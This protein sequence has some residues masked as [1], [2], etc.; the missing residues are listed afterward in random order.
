[1]G[2]L[3]VYELYKL[4][5]QRIVILVCMCAIIANAFTFCVVEHNY[6]RY[7]YR[8]EY[9]EKFK[10]VYDK[11]ESAEERI[12]SMQ[13]AGSLSNQYENYFLLSR[14]NMTAA[15]YEKTE[16][17]LVSKYGE[18]ILTDLEDMKKNMDLNTC[19]AFSYFSLEWKKQAEYVKEYN[20]FRNEME[21]RQNQLKFFSVF[22]KEE[23]YSYDN[24]LKTVKDFREL[25]QVDIDIGNHYG[26]QSF[27]D[28]HYS[29]VFIVCIASVLAAGLWQREKGML[30]LLKSKR[31]GKGSLFFAKIAV[32]VAG[33]F[34]M[35]L[36]CRGIEVC[37]SN[38]FYGMGN[39][40][41]SIQSISTYRN[42][43]L[44][45]TA[46][47]FMILCSLTQAVV[48]SAIGILLF[49]LFVVCR[50]NGY[51]YIIGG[52]G[53]VVSSMCYFFIL[54]TG[55]LSFFKYINLV[56]GMQATKLFGTYRNIDL[57]G[58]AVSVILLFAIFL[59]ILIMIG[60]I[61]GLIFWCTGKNIGRNG[62]F[63]IQ[64]SK[65]FRSG[66]SILQVQ[67]NEYFIREK[68]M[69]FCL[70]LLIYGIYTAFYSPLYHYTGTSPDEYFAETYYKD[71]IKDMEGML[72]E[73]TKQKISEREKYFDDVWEQIEIIS[74][75][76]EQD[77]EDYAKLTALNSQTGYPLQAFQELK[78]QYDMVKIR[79]KEGK[80]AVILDKYSWN[81]LFQ[82]AETE[83]KNLMLA[84]IVSIL[85]CG[86]VF[87]DRKKMKSLVASTKKGRRNL[88][89]KKYLIG[90]G[91]GVFAWLCL[92]LPEL[93][94]F[95][96]EK[97]VYLMSAAL[98]NLPLLQQVE[99][100]H[101]IGF[102]V[103]L[104][105]VSS[106]L[107]CVALSCLTMIL[108]D[109]TSDSFIITVSMIAGVSLVG[110]ILIGKKQGVFGAIVLYSTCPVRDL[111]LVSVLLLL[112]I[113]VSITL[114]ECELL[115]PKRKVVFKHGRK[116]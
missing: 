89:R 102:T 14:K 84:G 66:I 47:Q 113:L 23:S 7:I 103:M 90:I 9:Y 61:S 52:T 50:N 60:V 38:Y 77:T 19:R 51:I 25:G 43:C 109:L 45:L 65:K 94:L 76:D 72:T 85:L 17:K 2:K 59:V 108:V 96:R 37:I 104:I 16:K 1:M 79:Q 10:Q 28:Y 8:G 11:P 15:E 54:P 75:K 46:G 98:G 27:L 67:L 83:V 114:W 57:F 116:K 70:L 21:N 29:G 81:R 5:H 3:F 71:E 20:T 73:N 112:P 41:M 56:F 105:Y 111:F 87:S 93:V 95:L 100:E 48:A 110:A 53:L 92:V 115:Y 32:L 63:Q 62:S 18:E 106:L 42:C 107:F 35:T 12:K 82:N 30:T 33:I 68:K 101:S 69:I 34:L 4:F 6:G 24:L 49:L 40:S 78:E 39:L 97:S 36:L 86:T 31:K 58:K 26:I 88:W 80:N 74:K 13:R 91:G 44:K 99:E 64:F 55:S 22:S